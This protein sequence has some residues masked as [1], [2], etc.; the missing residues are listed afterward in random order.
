MTKKLLKILKNGVPTQPIFKL[1]LMKERMKYENSL[2]YK[3][4][5][6]YFYVNNTTTNSCWKIN[7]LQE[8]KIF[9]VKNYFLIPIS[10]SLFLEF[11]QLPTW[12]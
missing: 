1:K 10:F 12:L 4:N 11:V 3:K 5:F 9:F 6:Y 8:T 2:L 7:V